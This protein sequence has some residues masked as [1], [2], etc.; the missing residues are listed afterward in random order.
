MAKAL[1]LSRDELFDRLRDGDTLAEIA[2]AEGKQ[3]ADVRAAARAAAKAELDEAVA[4]GRLT[5]RQA[6][7]LL[8]AITERI[9]R[10][11]AD[12]PFRRGP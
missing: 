8:D 6:N 5:R 10:F 2:K 11:P 1:G 9:E 7:R 3:L 4:D 12:R